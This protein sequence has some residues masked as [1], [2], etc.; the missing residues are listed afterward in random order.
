M[1]QVWWGMS[2]ILAFK[3]LRWK[4]QKFKSSLSYV[5]KLSGRKGGRE[6]WREE[7]KEGKG[8]EGRET[9]E[10]RE[11]KKEGGRE[12]EKEGRKE[13]RKSQLYCKWRLEDKV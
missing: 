8:R 9:K 7:R 10:G 3:R 2:V 11:E 6:K 13:G 5:V 1:Q 12:G 4:D